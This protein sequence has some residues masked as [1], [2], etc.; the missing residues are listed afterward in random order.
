M[1][2]ESKAAPVFSGTTDGPES[3]HVDVLFV[4]VFEGEDTL[5]DLPGLDDATGGDIA[6]ARSSAEYR[7]RL[8]S[9]YTTRVVSGPYKAVRVAL[10]GAGRREDVDPERIRRIAAACSYTARLRSMGSAGIVIRAGWDPV[11]AAQMAADGMSTAEFDSGT[12][13][14][15][16]EAGT[17]PNRVIVVSPQADVEALNRAVIHGRT[18]GESSNWA[19]ALANEP[20]N[21]LTPTEFANRVAGMAAEAGLFVDVL[22]EA[23]IRALKMG[24][25][26]GVAQGS[27]APPRLVVLRHDPPGAPQGPVLGLVGKG[28]TFDTGGVSI[29]PADGM[30][31]MKYDMSGGAA[32]AAAMRAL[33][34]L[35]SPHR[36]IAVIPMSEN[37]VGGEAMRPGDVLTAASGTT[38]EIIN[39]DAE[40]RLILGDALWYAQE[41]GATHLVDVATLTGACVVAL[42]RAASGVF[43]TPDTWVEHV[44]AAG[45][46][47]GDRL[48]PL[49]LYEDYREMLRSDIADMMNSAGRW[50]GANTAAM[51]LREFIRPDRM[52]AHLDIAG[53]AWA[54][55]RR[56]YQAKGSTGVAIRTLVALGLQ[57]SI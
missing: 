21:V 28:I 50:G 6:H 25:L 33:A 53:T 11:H 31:R 27:Q 54:E 30:E 22:D 26:L 24:L 34:R 35:Q 52:W 36:V 32:V 42:G 4:P 56:A 7:A 43:G 47:A 20:S 12:Y 19:R 29:K 15:E 37:A 18:L 13:K 51:F 1:L 39:T 57:P 9:F 10:V 48:W 8:Y 14:S 49:P 16:K 2:G 45:A 38:V 23:R 41:L 44:R 5:D 17:F 3:V 46:T 55:E 40:G